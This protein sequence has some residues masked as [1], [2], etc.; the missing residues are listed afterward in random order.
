MIGTAQ[1][2]GE[3]EWFLQFVQAGIGRIK[4][5]SEQRGD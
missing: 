2:D 4:H 1:A 5:S 3:F